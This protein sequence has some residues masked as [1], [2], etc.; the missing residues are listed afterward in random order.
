LA[1]TEKQFPDVG[2]GDLYYGGTAYTNEGGLGIQWATEAESGTAPAAG[3]VD[4]PAPLTIPDG[5]FLIVPIRELYNR[6]PEFNA[7][8]HL[9]NA[10]IDGAYAVFNGADAERL[11]LAQGDVVAITLAKNLVVE[12]EARVNAATPAGVILLPRH[13]SAA[14]TLPVPVAGTVKVMEK[15]EVAHAS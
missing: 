12:V 11:G 13:L 6:E 4:T 5:S 7:S 1:K 14:P 3:S 15:V 8:R 2:G 9:M 10:H